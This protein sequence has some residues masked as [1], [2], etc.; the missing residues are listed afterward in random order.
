MTTRNDSWSAPRDV[1]RNPTP[2]AF[3]ACDESN[4]T[5][6]DRDAGFSLTEILVT[7]VLMGVTVV[8]VVTSLQVTVRASTVDRDQA[9]AFAWL[10][11]ASDEIYALDR[12]QCTSDGQGRL[13]AI[14]DYR[15]AARN[16]TIPVVWSTSATVANIDVIDVQYLGRGTADDDFEWSPTFC[17]E[18]AS[19]ADSPL[20]TQRVI[21]ELTIPNGG[22]SQ[23]LEMV[24]SQ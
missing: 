20:H 3:N 21:I 2:L 8:A 1:P 10:Q 14:A 11:A 15:T 22:G 4:G 24:K 5:S 18:G 13:D 16:A 9:T 6:Q 17:F 19:F 7:I 23:T 12:V